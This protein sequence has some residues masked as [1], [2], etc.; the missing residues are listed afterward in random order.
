SVFTVAPSPLRAEEVHAESP[1][2]GRQSVTAQQRVRLRFTPAEFDEALERGAR[3]ADAEDR[4]PI[5]LAGGAVEHA[6][7]LEARERVGRQ[8][9]RPQVAVV[10]RAVAAGEDVGERMREALPRGRLQHRDLA[11]DL[12]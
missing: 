3:A 1:A 5:R 8:H 12:G 9:L 2:S 4:L 10:A 6:G 7:L 11:P